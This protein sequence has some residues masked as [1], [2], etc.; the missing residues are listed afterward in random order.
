MKKHLA[1]ITLT[2]ILVGCATPPTYLQGQP[3]QP[4]TPTLADRLNS[5]ISAVTNAIVTNPTK[6]NDTTGANLQDGRSH[7]QN[8]GVANIIANSTSD[9]WP[10]VAVNIKKLPKWFYGLPPSGMRGRY[11]STD[12]MTISMNVW[13]DEKSTK[14]YDNVDVCGTDIVK[15][16]PF[17]DVGLMWKSF[18]SASGTKNTGTQRTIGP[19]PPMMLFPNKPGLDLFF[20]MNGNYYVGSIMSTLGY[21]WNETQDFRFWIVNLPTQAEVVRQ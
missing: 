4:A 16:V 1:P 20:Q 14:N 19:L 18:S 17:Q 15:N 9:G 3:N 11:S 10:R 8:I 7:L 12:C 2:F 13:M 21:N 5:S 6:S